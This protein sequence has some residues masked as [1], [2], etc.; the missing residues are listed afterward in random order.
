MLWLAGSQL[1][2][3]NSRSFRASS[4]SQLSAQKH[5]SPPVLAIAKAQ[6]QVGGR[7]QIAAAWI[8]EWYDQSQLTVDSQA[9]G[10]I[11]LGAADSLR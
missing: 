4:L 7:T 1:T 9:T 8:G 11:Y 2:G 6:P 5:A 10:E 3:P